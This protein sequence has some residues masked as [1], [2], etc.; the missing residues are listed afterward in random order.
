MGLHESS[1]QVE[2]EPIVKKI[3]TGWQLQ[4]GRRQYACVGVN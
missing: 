2:V 4:Y 1:P 3:T